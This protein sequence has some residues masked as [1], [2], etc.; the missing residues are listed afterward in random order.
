V[1][2]EKSLNTSGHQSFQNFAG[3]VALAL[4]HHIFSHFQSQ[5][6]LFST[7]T[8]QKILLRIVHRVEVTP[9]LKRFLSL[10]GVQPRG[11]QKLSLKISHECEAHRN[12]TIEAT[13]ED[14]R[15]GLVLRG[16]WSTDITSVVYNGSRRRRR[17]ET[18]DRTKLQGYPDFSTHFQ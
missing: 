12:G 1:S 15:R 14:L 4:A 5:S 2:L 3:L 11:D 10:G 6:P 8:I 13:Y 7:K 16:W 17:D 9:V 18:C